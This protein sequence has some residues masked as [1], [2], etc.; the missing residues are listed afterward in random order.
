MIE[1]CRESHLAHE[2]LGTD[3]A[4]QIGVKHFDGDRPVVTEIA[5]EPD[6]RHPASAKL[7]LYLIAISQLR[8]EPVAHR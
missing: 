3:G 4:R 2:P 8:L 6:G 5:P 7:A 1:M